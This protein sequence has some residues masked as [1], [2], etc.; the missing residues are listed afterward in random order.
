MLGEASNIGR[1]GA[2]RPQSPF[3][4][5]GARV[6]QMDDGRRHAWVFAPGGRPAAGRRAAGAT[7]HASKAAR[8]GVFPVLR[9][10]RHVTF[11]LILGLAA[12]LAQ[13]PSDPPLGDARGVAAR[14]D[15]AVYDGAY[16]LTARPDTAFDMLAR[17]PG[18]VFDPGLSARGFA[19]TAGNVLIDGERPATKND[20]LQDYLG[21]SP[22]STWR[23]S[24]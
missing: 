10:V 24:S 12:V 21:G 9:R 13:P 6:P 1:E 5:L 7:C 22:R 4:S 17:I 3:A 8:G 19:G 16:F 23:G 11:I 15:G 2:P 14:T 18:F 20:N